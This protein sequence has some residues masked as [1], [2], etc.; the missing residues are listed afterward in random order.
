MH[1]SVMYPSPATGLTH[2]PAC[3]KFWWFPAAVFLQVTLTIDNPKNI[4]FGNI[5]T[6]ILAQEISAISVSAVSTKTYIGRALVKLA[7]TKGST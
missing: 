5:G 2:P 4:G 1:A 3:S 6:H 7:A